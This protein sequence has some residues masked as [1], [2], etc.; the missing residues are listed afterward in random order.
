MNVAV[1]VKCFKIVQTH[2]DYT[3]DWAMHHRIKT[4]KKETERTNISVIELAEY[5]NSLLKMSCL[6]IYHY[7]ARTYDRQVQNILCFSLQVIFGTCKVN[8]LEIIEIFKLEFR[9]EVALKQL[10]VQISELSEG[11][12]SGVEPEV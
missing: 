1:Y 5:F 10:Q 7:V 8:L 12:N 2:N 9:F 4:L 11:N 3:L 6:L